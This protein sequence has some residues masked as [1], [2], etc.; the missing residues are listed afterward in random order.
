[1]H[2]EIFSIGIVRQYKILIVIY[3]IRNTY[4]SLNCTPSLANRILFSV[5]V[6]VLFTRYP[7]KT[8]HIDTYLL[9]RKYA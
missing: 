6:V 3:V 9:L 8:W 2:A 7:I 1:M 4:S 5:T